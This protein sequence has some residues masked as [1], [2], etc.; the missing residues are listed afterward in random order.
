MIV[1]I[2][3]QSAYARTNADMT[4][5]ENV[6]FYKKKARRL[7]KLLKKKSFIKLLPYGLQIAWKKMEKFCKMT[8]KLDIQGETWLPN[9]IAI[10]EHHKPKNPFTDNPD[11]I[12]IHMNQ[13]GFEILP[14]N[15]SIFIAQ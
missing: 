9:S 2:S 14:Q 15:F 7:E 3:K 5:I 4:L 12:F 1:N 13:V 10:N 6:T 8:R 11:T